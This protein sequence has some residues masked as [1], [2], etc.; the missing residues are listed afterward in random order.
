VLPWLL[1]GGTLALHHG[2]D[3]RA[4]ATQLDT[5][6]EATV[7]VPGPA[8]APLL[9]AG[10]LKA[11]VNTVLALWR[12]PERLELC[13]PWL[14]QAALVDV[15]A[16]GEIGL[17]AARRGADGIPRALA[18]GPLAVPQGG[19]GTCVIVETT[20]SKSG[21]LA[22][23]GAMV[24]THAFPPGAMYGKDYAP[25]AAGF[26]DTGYGCRRDGE[27]LVVTGSPA[28]IAT[29]GGYRFSKVALEAE[30]ANVEAAT[31]VSVP[32]GSIGERLAGAAADPKAALAALRGRGVNPLISGAFC[33]RGEADAA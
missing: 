19:D 29:I 28:G 10:L 24:A 8:S 14:G 7:I 4:L 15:A 5:L 13:A 25:D 6:E 30:V 33:P 22:L 2:C 18:C 21:S 12:A 20:R 17:L 9:E 1:C 26:I 31:I 3:P 23:R 11:P 32:D 16:F 27:A